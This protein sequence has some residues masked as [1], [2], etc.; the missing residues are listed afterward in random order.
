MLDAASI[1]APACSGELDAASST[2]HDPTDQLVEHPGM[3]GAT[4]TAWWDFSELFELVH[5]AP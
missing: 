5:S 2:K 3:P 1:K 4:S